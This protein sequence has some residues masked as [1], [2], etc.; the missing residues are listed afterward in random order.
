MPK[1]PIRTR[2][3][4]VS[5][6]DTW[7]FCNYGFKIDFELEKKG[8][9]IETKETYKGSES[10]EQIEK[11]LGKVGTPVELKSFDEVIKHS[12]K[13]HFI[14]G[15]EKYLKSTTMPLVG[16][17]DIYFCVGGDFYVLDFKTSREPN[18]PSKRF[19]SRVWDGQGTT[20]FCYGI[21]IEENTNVIPKLGINY[22]SDIELQKI[23]S[24]VERKEFGS[25]DFMALYEKSE[26]IPY[27]NELK[28]YVIK[29]IE[30]I[31][32]FME[33]KVE[34]SRSHNS[35]GKCSG[36]KRREYCSVKLV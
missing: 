7:S 6:L 13:G 25:N 12:L 29:Q 9:K 28:S 11:E 17:I 32:G 19:G 35:P 14:Y 4:H 15:Q 22:I 20:L 24:K 34:P 30:M 18:I 31:A 16:K 26:K 21:L 2:P 36:C 10:H 8:I 23:T 27:T 33:G 1:Y 3:V 5:D